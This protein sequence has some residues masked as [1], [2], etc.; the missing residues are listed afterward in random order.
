MLFNE[1]LKEKYQKLEPLFN[2]LFAL[3]IKNQ[4]H[5]GDMLLVMENAMIRDEIDTEDPSKYH[6]HYNLGPGMDYHCETENH[7][8]IKDYIKSTVNLPYHDYLK[9][10]EYSQERSEEIDQIQKQ[11]SLTI[12]VEMLIYL[13]I[14]EG[15][16]FLK[17]MYQISRLINGDYYD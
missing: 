12:Q 10:H 14:W 8:F 9:M 16:T 2:E 6:G 4:A 1:V 3:A 5:P 15:E 13:K 7:E 17:K 11:E